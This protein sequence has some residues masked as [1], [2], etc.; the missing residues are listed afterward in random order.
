MPV[1]A[2]GEAAPVLQLLPDIGFR[3]PGLQTE[4]VAAEIDG[5]AEGRWW[6]KKPGA[7]AIQLILPV[8]PL[9]GHSR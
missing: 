5:I 1:A 7:K 3:V 2:D 9:N 4:A 6:N 8:F